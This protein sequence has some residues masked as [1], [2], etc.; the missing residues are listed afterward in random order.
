MALQIKEIKPIYTN[1]LKEW[2]GEAR[3]FVT[4]NIMRPVCS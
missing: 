4:N 2:G 3:F 1:S